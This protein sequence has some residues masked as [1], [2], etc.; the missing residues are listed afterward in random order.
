M[1]SFKT[2][3]PAR[4]SRFVLHLFTVYIRITGHFRLDRLVQFCYMKCYN[5]SFIMQC[6]IY[7]N[8]HSTDQL[9]FTNK[10][11]SRK[12]KKYRIY[13]ENFRKW[14]ED[15]DKNL[16]CVE[17]S[18]DNLQLILSLLFPFNICYSS[19]ILLLTLSIKISIGLYIFKNP[20]ASTEKWK[21]KAKLIGSNSEMSW[22]ELHSINVEQLFRNFTK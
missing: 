12:L 22:E 11:D 6:A 8:S 18:S 7:S 5:Q 3:C 16:E 13:S 20:F 21:Q 2:D 1:Y 15:F 10:K 4:Y 14:C 19:F 17:Y 9:C